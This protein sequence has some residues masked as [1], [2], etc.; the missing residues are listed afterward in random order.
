MRAQTYK[1]GDTIRLPG[2]YRL[3][4]QVHAGRLQSWVIRDAAGSHRGKVRRSAEAGSR[5]V[6]TC[7]DDPTVLCTASKRREAALGVLLAI[8]EAE[9]EALQKLLRHLRGP[10]GGCRVDRRVR[11]KSI[12][13]DAEK[14]EPGQL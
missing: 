2:G 13:V 14:K 1:A 3:D 10:L 8:A 5:W 9:Q 7:L 6:G 11:S 12:E 4:C